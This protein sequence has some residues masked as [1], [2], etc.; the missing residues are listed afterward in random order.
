[1]R[2]F[3]GSLLGGLLIGL[4]LAFLWIGYEGITYSQMNV[5]GVEE[6]IVHEMDF[7]FV[8]YSSLLVVAIAVIIYL[9]WNFINKKREE[10]FLREYQNNSK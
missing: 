7:D 3:F 6:V 10:R 1:M 2:K 5:A 4:P 9:I 8:F